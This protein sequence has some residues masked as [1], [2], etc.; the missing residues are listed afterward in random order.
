M[1]G[2]AALGASVPLSCG[3]NGEKEV[4]RTASIG[5]SSIEDMLLKYRQ[6][7]ACSWLPFMHNHV[8]DHEY[9][10]FMCNT[11]PDGSNITSEKRAGYEGRG[12]WIYS[13]LYNNFDAIEPDATFMREFCP[14]VS[15]GKIADTIFEDREY[16]LD[17]AKKSFDFLMKNRPKGL[18]MWPGRFHRNGKPASAPSA[19]VN[20][21]LYIA[22]GI[23]EYARATGDM[24]YWQMAKKQLI[25]CLA[26]YDREDYN[27]ESGRG[28]IG[29]E[30]PKY[31]GKRVLDDWMLFLWV[32]TQM[33]KQKSDMDLLM[34]V[35]QCL[36]T[37]MN[38]FYNPKTGL[39]HEI[40]DHDYTRPANGFGNVVNFGNSIQALW[41]VLAAAERID[42]NDQF[43]TAAGRFRKHIE[44]AWD[45]I[46]GGMLNVCTNIEE[47]RWNLGK[48]HYA[49]VEPLVG[50]L[51]II[52]R[53][54]KQW[55]HDW[56]TKIH[57]YETGTFHL[58][59]HGQPLWMNSSERKGTFDFERS[60][61]IGNF[62]QPRHLILNTVK[63][64]NMLAQNST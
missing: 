47:N 12:L 46:Y 6:H 58:A 48:A 9:G 44:V 30:A 62:H 23:Q 34:I 18:G 52:D 37:I 17:M 38:K 56:F 2:T 49:Q 36:D 32:A 4:K 29:K 51:M 60:K 50:L 27:P 1:A 7:L 35:T 55:A 19:T 16:F 14:D 28:Y 45:D 53:L 26:V 33:L 11:R 61:R 24:S 43:N 41:H 5:N 40:L 10:G 3:G 42:N 31:A 64:T 15:A 59:R 39:V 22:D 21:D 54:D 8:I 13:S 63:L 20:A 25:K 57:S